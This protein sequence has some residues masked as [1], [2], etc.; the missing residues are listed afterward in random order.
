MFYNIALFIHIL[1]RGKELDCI[2]VS[3]RNVRLRC[4]YFITNIF[5]EHPNITDTVEKNG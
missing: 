5:S 3:D 2:F 4:I 1:C